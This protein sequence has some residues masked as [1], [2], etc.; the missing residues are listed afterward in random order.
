VKA[1][2]REDLA[3]VGP[4]QDDLDEAV[5]DV[6]EPCLELPVAEDPRDLTAVARLLGE[7]EGCSSHFALETPGDP[8]RFRPGSAQIRASRPPKGGSAGRPL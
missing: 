5:G 4:L 7:G 1:L 8:R 6:T 2:E 3:R